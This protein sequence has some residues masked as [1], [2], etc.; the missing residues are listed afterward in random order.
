MNNYDFT[1]FGLDDLMP[2]NPMP[3]QNNNATVSGNL[4]PMQMPNNVNPNSTMDFNSPTR[5]YTT[6]EAFVK[7]NLFPDLYKGY[8]NYRPVVL[9][10]TNEQ[11]QMYLNLSQLS[12]AAHELNLYLDNFPNDRGL[13]RLFNDYRKMAD[14]AIRAYEA[15]YGPVVITSDQ[16][17]QFPWVWSNQNFPW[18]EGGM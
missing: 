13:I 18:D 10:P 14:Q 6:Q 1:S 4:T 5:L 17:D 8:K 15:K 16:L 3:F 7:G 9:T 11:Q 2:V 12:F